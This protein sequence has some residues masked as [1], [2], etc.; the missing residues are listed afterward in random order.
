M[1]PLGYGMPGFGGYA[2]PASTH[3]P[4]L[5]SDQPD[6]DSVPYPSIID[7]IEAMITKY[8]QRQALRTAGETFESLRLYDISEIT[9]LTVDELGTEKFGNVVLGD[10]QFLLTR[11]EKEVKRLNKLAKQARL[12]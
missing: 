4:L 2:P 9:A 8:P 10:A 6:D 5:S 1:V 11:V 12:H 7:F 3:T